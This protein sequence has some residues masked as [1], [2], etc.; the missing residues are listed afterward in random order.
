MMKRIEDWLVPD[1]VVLGASPGDL[2][3][4]LH[5]VLEIGAHGLNL[6]PTQV[7][8]MARVLAAGD[9]GE[10]V[11]VGDHFVLVVADVDGLGEPRGFCLVAGSNF[12]LS[13]TDVDRGDTR[14]VILAL[15]PGRRTAFRARLVPVLRRILVVEGGGERLVSAETAEGALDAVPLRDLALPESTLV[16]SAVEPATYRV[17][18]GTPM[19]EL[20]GLMIRRKL[21]A[22]PVVGE[23]YEVLGIVTTGDALRHLMAR[24]RD[25]EAG[26]GEAR[27]IMT[28]AVLCV[29]EEQEL[30]EVA[31]LMVTRDV[32]QLPVVR[33]GRLV[34]F[35]TRD[36]VLAALFGEVPGT[37]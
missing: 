24:A 15:V 9:G 16:G 18:P 25:G 31:Q 27:E 6:G 8:R 21:H 33:E 29:S 7:D 35:I 5:T 28:R 1:R 14:G 13:L 3:D 32:E 2:E 34:G 20:M 17:Y 19:E 26:G 23:N 10:M 30:K 36:T 4:A 22:V 11:R 12:P 37:E